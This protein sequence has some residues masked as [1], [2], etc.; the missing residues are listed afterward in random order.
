MSAEPDPD[1]G[2]NEQPGDADERY[3]SRPGAAHTGDEPRAECDEECEKADD[4]EI[5]ERLNVGVLHAPVVLGRR[6][7]LGRLGREPAMRGLEVRRVG[8]VVG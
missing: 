4:A 7:R 2:R 3:R 1:A 5:G 8:E 6:E